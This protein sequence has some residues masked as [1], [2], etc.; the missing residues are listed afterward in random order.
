[1][2]QFSNE[3]V[4][5]YRAFIKAFLAKADESSDE[6]AEELHTKAM[7]LL[8]TLDT[9]TDEAER[10]KYQYAA[11]ALECVAAIRY[12]EV[13]YYHRAS[14]CFLRSAQI[15]YEHHSYFPACAVLWHAL[16]CK[17]YPNRRAEIERF[18]RKAHLKYVPH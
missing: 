16:N 13:T 18:Y 8:S 7:S 6:G 9:T 12:F 1:M 15:L 2:I 11:A 10:S 4:Q 17:P 14:F 3:E 5:N